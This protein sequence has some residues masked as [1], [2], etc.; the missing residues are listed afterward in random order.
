MYRSANK[1]VFSA[2]NHVIWCPKYRG[3]VLVGRVETRLKEIIG[4][5]VGELGGGVI[6]VEV[7]AD[8]VHLLVEVPPAVPLSK[9]VQLLKGR[10]W[11][12]GRREFPALRRL[13]VLWSP[14]WFVSTVGGAPLGVVRRDV[15]HQKRAA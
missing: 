13:P 15:E 11:R 14:S 3:R 4:E 8:H 9:R 10:S 2:K 5:V 7:M 12:L 6:E 1:T